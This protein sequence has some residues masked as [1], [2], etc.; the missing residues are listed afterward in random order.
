MIFEKIKARMGFTLIE[1][2][3]VVAIL[4]LLLSLV[5]IYWREIQMRSRD[6]RR[7]SDIQTL[8]KALSMY[9]IQHANYPLETEEIEID[10]SDEITQALTS[11]N[12]LS[13]PVKDPINGIGNG[14]N[15]VYT[16][17]SDNG[18]SYLMK[19][20]LETDSIQGKF[21]GCGNEAAP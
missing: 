14:V 7:V 12:L 10:G 2:I 18:N 8:Q 16:Y 19:Y 1:L 5:L 3:I 11:E 21:K 15:Y 6:N 17:E 13:A 20:C 4:G 9:Q